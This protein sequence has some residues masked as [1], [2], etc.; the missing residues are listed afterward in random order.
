MDELLAQTPNAI[1]QTR[2]ELPSPFPEEIA[3]VDQQGILHRLGQ[4]EQA[5]LTR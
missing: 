2:R 4:I 1:E 5:K 3:R